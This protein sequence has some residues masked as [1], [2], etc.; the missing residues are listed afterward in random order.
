[1]SQ[2]Y[3]SKSMRHKNRKRVRAVGQVKTKVRA[4]KIM[5]LQKDLAQQTDNIK[6]SFFCVFLNKKYL[7]F[8]HKRIQ[9]K[10]FSFSGNGSQL[11]NP[12]ISGAIFTLSL[13]IRILNSQCVVGA[14]DIK[15]L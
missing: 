11:K 3:Q 12:D 8:V 14:R 6:K 2:N 10:N 13:S 5:V 9:L 7:I 1:M 4:A 15:V